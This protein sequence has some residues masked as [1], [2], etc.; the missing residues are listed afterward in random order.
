MS[1]KETMVKDLKQYFREDCYIVLEQMKIF[2]I[3]LLFSILNGRKGK[4][5]EY[6]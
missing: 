4:K 5:Y 6:D 2:Q 1:D 3:K